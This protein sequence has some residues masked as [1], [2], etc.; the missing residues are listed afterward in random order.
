LFSTF[1][2]EYKVAFVKTHWPFFY[3]SARREIYKEWSIDVIWPRIDEFIDLWTRTKSTD[4]FAAGKAMQDAIRNA[5]LKPPDWPANVIEA[6]TAAKRKPT[7]DL[8]D[9]IPF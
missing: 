7:S 9:E 5:G 3:S 4:Y 1:E 2:D 8:D 6:P